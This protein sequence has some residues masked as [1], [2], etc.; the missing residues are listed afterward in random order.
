MH[1]EESDHRHRLIELYRARFGEHI[2]LIRRQNIKDFLARRPPWFHPILTVPM[3]RREVETM[4]QESRAFYQA[5]TAQTSDAAVR[6]LLGDLA[7]EG[8]KHYELAGSM[9]TEQKTSGA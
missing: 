1:D 6:Q 3:I 8:A 5:A 7:A 9:E 2:P 4:E